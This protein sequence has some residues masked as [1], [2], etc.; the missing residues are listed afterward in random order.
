MLPHE[1][2]LAH[3]QQ[4]APCAG[5]QDDADCLVPQTHSHE[6]VLE[7]LPALQLHTWH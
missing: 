7:A 6:L 3:A 2:V 1:H 4:I 5:T